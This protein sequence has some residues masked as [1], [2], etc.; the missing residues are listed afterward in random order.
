MRLP[1]LALT[2]AAVAV[3][4]APA[5]AGTPGHW[6]R[7][8]PTNGVN[9]DQASLLRGTDGV[10]HVAWLQ[11][12]AADPTK[13]DIATA[14]VSA[15]GKL[16]ATVPV[17]TGWAGVSNPALTSVPGGGLRV[18]FG[19]IRTTNGGETQ[20]NL[21]TSSAPGAGAPWTLQTG[22]VAEGGAAYSSPM[23]AA[24]LPDGTPLVAWGSA[25]GVFVHR[26]LTPGSGDTDR[27][28]PLGG[29]CGYDAG[30]AVDGAS[31][32]AFVAWYSNATGHEGVFAQGVDSGAAQLMPGTVVNGNS[33]PQLARTPIA[34]RPGKAGVYVAYPGGY[35][36]A[37]RVLLWKVGSATSATLDKGGAD[38]RGVTLAAAPD[39]RLWVLWGQRIGDRLRVFARRSNP[40][41]SQFG[42]KVAIAPPPGGDQIWKLDANAQA[43]PVDVVGSFTTPGALSAWHTQ[44]RPG[45]TL[46]VSRSKQTVKVRVLDAGDPLGG[47]KVSISGDSGTTASNGRV[48]LTLK[49]G[50]KLHVTAAK[51]GYTTATA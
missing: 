11:K 42:A 17:E 29:C 47:V 26:G 16:G 25:T 33:N 49:K 34:G 50:A 39:G 5:E 36:T 8:T 32:A 41:V 40:A 14:P 35:P 1:L 51:K 27:Q 24:T 45:L 38:H 44:I 43:G 28:A 4:A 9:I 21:S 22:N 23:S 18:F 13:Q 46:E 20:T 30:L 2:A 10:L 12:N 19:G 37:D 15:A 48:T 7:I 3:M 6:T 31:G